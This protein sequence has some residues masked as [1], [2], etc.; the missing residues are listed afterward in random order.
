MSII[1]RKKKGF[2]SP[3]RKWFKEKTMIRDLLLGQGSKFAGYFN[4]RTIEAVL[5]QHAKGYDRERHIFLL[6][7]IYYW[8]EE[9]A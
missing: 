6:L 8:L 1:K 4:R 7:G 5:E 3:T 9:F 2:A